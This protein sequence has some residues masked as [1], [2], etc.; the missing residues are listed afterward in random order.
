MPALRGSFTYTRFFVTGDMPEDFREKFMR[1][2]R[3]RAMKPLE[4]DD[5]DLERSGWVKL[6][7]PFVNE[8]TYDDVFYNEYL[9]L[10]F[11]TD[12]WVLPGPVLKVRMKEAETA[13]LAKK[14]R[15]KLSKS[16]KAELKLLVAKKLKKTMEPATRVVDVSWSMNEGLVRFFSHAQKS[17]ALM[18][19]L[20]KR[21]FGLDLVPESPYTL[22]ARIGLDPPQEAAWNEL[23][24]TYLATERAG[25]NDEA[26]EEE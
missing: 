2:I 21:T 6:G 15:E 4:P 25:A 10:G 8:L 11:R 20:F 9:N 22:A 23:E 19:E 17:G 18:A 16:E 1:S 24:M 12:R 3:L 5:E 7:E 26:A 13:Y 14:G